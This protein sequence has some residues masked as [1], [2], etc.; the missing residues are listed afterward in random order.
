MEHAHPKSGGAC[1]SG[2]PTSLAIHQRGALRAAIRSVGA[3]KYLYISRSEESANRHLL[4]VTCTQPLLKNWVLS[5]KNL[6]I[7]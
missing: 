4:V 6:V 1:E 3:T 5:G 7:T 2:T